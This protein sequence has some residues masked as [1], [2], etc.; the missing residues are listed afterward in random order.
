MRHSNRYPKRG[1]TSITVWSGTVKGGGTTNT[2]A[3]V[4]TKKMWKNIL[5]GQN[6]LLFCLLFLN[7][8]PSINWMIQ[9][10]PWGHTG[11][12]QVKPWL[13]TN[14]NPWA[15][16]SSRCHQ[17]GWNSKRRFCDLTEIPGKGG[18]HLARAGN[19][20][21]F[22][23]SLWAIRKCPSTCTPTQLWV[24]INFCCA[25]KQDYI[26]YNKKWRASHSCPTTWHNFFQRECLNIL[27]VM[28]NH[29][30]A[31]KGKEKRELIIILLKLN[32]TICKI[33]PFIYHKWAWNGDW[34][35]LEQVLII[36][37]NNHYWFFYGKLPKS[38]AD[39]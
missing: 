18:Q 14:T 1:Q 31:E 35:H 8:S 20:K 19:I 39:L 30:D 24:W 28:F 38:C 15:Q 37:N 27:N 25:Q 21:A 22:D 6:L 4:S 32:I 33:I 34:R 9:Y 17:N 3:M 13:G 23:L 36:D 26:K 11:L 29:R 10:F 7:I 16:L 12:V 5:T 2:R